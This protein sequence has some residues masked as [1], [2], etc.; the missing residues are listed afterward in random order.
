MSDPALYGG[1]LDRAHDA[2]LR[3]S[4]LPTSAAV[5]AALQPSWASLPAAATKRDARGNSRAIR[6]GSWGSPA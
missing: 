6:S 4:R 3:E 5:T 2:F 1:L